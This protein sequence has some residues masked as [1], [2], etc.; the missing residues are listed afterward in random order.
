MLS[1]RYD[2]KQKAFSASAER[3]LH[4]PTHPDL[5]LLHQQAQIRPVEMTSM[6]RGTF[7][8]TSEPLEPS[9]PF[10]QKESLHI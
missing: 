2:G 8:K 7:K 10:P 4:S 9:E 3:F 5:L 6:A 1:H